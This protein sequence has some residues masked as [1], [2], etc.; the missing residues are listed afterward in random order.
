MIWQRRWERRYAAS[1]RLSVAATDAKNGND[2][3]Y[4]WAGGCIETDGRMFRCKHLVA[5][6]AGSVR[7][8]CDVE[9]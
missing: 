8:A 5:V 6:R 9:Q 1:P 7:D 2:V 4:S 3:A